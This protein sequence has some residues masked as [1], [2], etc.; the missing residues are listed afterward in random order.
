MIGD[1]LSEYHYLALA[2]GLSQELA[3]SLYIY[4]HFFIDS[5]C[6]FNNYLLGQL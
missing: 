6:I 3:G 2:A 4:I 1:Q 5:N